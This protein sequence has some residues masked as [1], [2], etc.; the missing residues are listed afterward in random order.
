MLRLK[1]AT[2]VIL[3]L[4]FV[5]CIKDKKKQQNIVQLTYG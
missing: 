3:L 1:C 4:L 2:F 5:I